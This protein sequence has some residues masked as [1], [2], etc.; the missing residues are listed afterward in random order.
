MPGQQHVSVGC[1]NGTSIYRVDNPETG[2]SAGFWLARLPWTVESD[3]DSSKSDGD[4]DDTKCG[5][6]PRRIHVKRETRIELDFTHS[7]DGRCQCLG[8]DTDAPAV[9]ELL[10]VALGFTAFPL[11]PM[12]PGAEAV[13]VENTTS[14]MLVMLGRV[15]RLPALGDIDLDLWGQIY[16]P[17]PSPP[18]TLTTSPTP[19]VEK[20]SID[21]TS[22]WRK[23]SQYVQS[24]KMRLRKYASR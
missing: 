18:P 24:L 22:F 7:E 20:K 9:R 3:D 1:I 11:A 19:S 5:G 10:D 17:A 4:S 15:L 13:V 12:C 21:K 14:A 6:A 23:P 2:C 8:Q 16:M